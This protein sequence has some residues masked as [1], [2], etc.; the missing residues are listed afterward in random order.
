MGATSPIRILVST[1][2]ELFLRKDATHTRVEI[3]RE[4]RS[5]E[6]GALQPKT[7]TP[8][9][10]LRV[11]YDHRDGMHAIKLVQQWV[12]IYALSFLKK[13]NEGGYSI[14]L[15]QTKNMDFFDPPKRVMVV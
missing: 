7:Q 13:K 8:M 11:K 4:W 6:R 9:E 2:R 14:L 3:G 5:L 10:L 12:H 1:L 15:P